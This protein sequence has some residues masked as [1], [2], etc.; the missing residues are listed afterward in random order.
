VVVRFTG[1]SGVVAGS[2]ADGRY[3]LIEHQGK[4]HGGGGAALLA[5]HRDAFFRLF[6]D[7]NGD[8]KVDATDLAAFQQAYRSVSGVRQLPMRGLSSY[9]A[10]FDVDQNGVI[11]AVDYYQFLRRYGTRLPA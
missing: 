11:D 1:L 4:I 8:A 7:V 9:R 5:D 10:Y 2:L 3:T 6:G